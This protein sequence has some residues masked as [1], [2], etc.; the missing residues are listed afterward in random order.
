MFKISKETQKEFSNTQRLR[1]G[2]WCYQQE[3]INLKKE[4]VIPQ[5]VRETL[6]ITVI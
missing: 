4:E 5:L 2:Q 6:N 3:I 1:M